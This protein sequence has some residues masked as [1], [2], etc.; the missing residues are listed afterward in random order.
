MRQITPLPPEAA[1]LAPTGLT[2]KDQRRIQDALD[3]S[4]SANTRRAYNQACRRF[5]AWV[6]PVATATPCRR[7]RS[8]WLRSWRSWPNRGNRGH[9]S[10]HQVRPDDGPPLDQ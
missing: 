4:T 3:S 2:V 5:E 6:A 9:P 8:W 10:A 1:E 7:R